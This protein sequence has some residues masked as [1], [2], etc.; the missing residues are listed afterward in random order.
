MLG[1]P[2]ARRR[3]L[4]AACALPFASLARAAAPTTVRVGQCLPLT[5][6]LGPVVVPIAE[7][8]KPTSVR[9]GIAEDGTFTY[10]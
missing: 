7:G 9:V 6:P 1:Q 4:A 5:G 3:M 10:S 2:T 8:Q